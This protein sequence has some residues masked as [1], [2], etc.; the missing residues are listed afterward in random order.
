MVWR[1]RARSRY[2]RDW[3]VTEVEV[4]KFKGCQL[5][6]SGEQAIKNQGSYRSH[7]LDC[8]AFSLLFHHTDYSA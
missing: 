2:V 6:T 3:S 7:S 4:E 8:Q 1:L 5:S